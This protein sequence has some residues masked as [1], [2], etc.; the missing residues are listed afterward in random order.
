VNFTV[1]DERFVDD[2][3]VCGHWIFRCCSLFFLTFDGGA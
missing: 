2:A 1:I 3:K